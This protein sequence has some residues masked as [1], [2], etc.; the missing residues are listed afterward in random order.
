MGSIS[1]EQYEGIIHEMKEL[2]NLYQ[3]IREGEDLSPPDGITSFADACNRF[4]DL[5][6]KAYRLVTMSARVELKSASKNISEAIMDENASIPMHGAIFSPLRQR[7]QSPLWPS[8]H[9]QHLRRASRICR[10]TPHSE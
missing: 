3:I 7:K 5:E 4:S 10:T 9:P 1:R 6:E 8:H 2:Q